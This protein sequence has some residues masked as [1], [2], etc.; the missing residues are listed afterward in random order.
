MTTKPTYEGAIPNAIEALEAT[1]ALLQNRYREKDADCFWIV[2]EA[3]AALRALEKA[4]KPRLKHG[5]LTGEHDYRDDDLD[6]DGVR[7]LVILRDATKG[8]E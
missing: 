2:S 4:V 8:G 7:C 6:Y 1:H 5:F 3:L